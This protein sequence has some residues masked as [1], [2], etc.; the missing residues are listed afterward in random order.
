M[1]S[2]STAEMAGRAERVIV[3]SV[4][5]SGTHLIQE[6]MIALGYRIYGQS[7]VTPDIR[8]Q[9]DRETRRRMI[10][11]VYEPE[12]SEELEVGDEAVFQKASDEAWD[13]LAWS[14]QARF[15]MPLENRYG[16]EVLNSGLI[17]QALDR[18]VGSDFADTPAGVAW[19]L[20]EF[21][22][23]KLDGH[24]LREW[25]QTGEPRIIFNYRDPRDVVLSAVNFLSGYT[26]KGYGNFA[27]FQIFNKI[28]NALPTLDD[29]L[30]Y[31]LTDPFFPGCHAYEKAL[32]LLAH[33]DVC[34]ISFEELIGPQG[35]GSTD[36]QHAA[37]ARVSRFLG[38][39]SDAESVAPHLF[40][41]DAF[42]FF[43]GQI[44]AWRGTFTPEH[45]KLFINRYGE[46]LATYG[47]K[48]AM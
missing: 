44:G 24:F 32:W 39:N 42:S 43:K 31:A 35:G 36:A 25:S 48:A 1:A 17:Q 2:N 28:L 15:G 27:E 40:R 12:V 37:I 29:K 23:P 38:V 8:P 18:T 7:R 5:K 14:W 30:I 33:P 47:Y 13:A 6:L 46:M 41:R 9:L 16:R 26:E 19:I 4:M 21:D 34:K 20:T 3:I 22:V 11:M 10:H 45:E